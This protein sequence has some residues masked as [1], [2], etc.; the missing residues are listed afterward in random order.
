MGSGSLLRHSLSLGT[1][2]G[3]AAVIS[4]CSLNQPQQMAHPQ[5]THTEKSDAVSY[6]DYV[7]PFIGSDG[8]GKTYPGATVPYGMVQLSPDNGRYGWDWISGYFYP[9]NVI[10]GFSHT[11]L[12]GTGAGIFT[13]YLLCR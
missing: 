10:A 9:D 7:D 13:I 6:T 1:I 3:A 12:S 5:P 2:F 8:K 4:A 11:H